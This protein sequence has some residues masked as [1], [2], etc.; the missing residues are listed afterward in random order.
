VAACD[1][2]SADFVLMHQDT[3]G[4]LLGASEL[5]LLGKA[6]KYAGIFGKEVR[7]VPSNVCFRERCPPLKPMIREPETEGESILG[8]EAGSPALAVQLALRL[9][10]RSRTR[11]VGI[12]RES[13][14]G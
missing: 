12:F 2:Q 4:P 1:L 7:I 9:A 3:F 14:R 8:R 6:I 10:L 13:M 11:C 5:L